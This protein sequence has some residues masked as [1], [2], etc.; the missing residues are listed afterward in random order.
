MAN[1][2]EFKK[3]D[4]AVLVV[5]PGPSERVAEFIDQARTQAAGVADAPFPVLLDRDCTACD[6][7]GI[8]GDLAK[9]SVYVLDKRGNVVYAYVG[10]TLTD[11]PSVKVLLAQLDK[12]KAR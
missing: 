4:G 10:E 7:L 5:F 9:P 8:R 11:R 2:G 1:A 12:L 6:A 3:R